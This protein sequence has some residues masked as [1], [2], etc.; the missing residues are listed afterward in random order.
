MCAPVA[1]RMSKHMMDVI[2]SDM[3]SKLLSISD[4]EMDLF[5]TPYL[6]QSILVGGFIERLANKQPCLQLTLTH[7][8]L[9]AYRI[10][11]IKEI[12]ALHTLIDMNISNIT[13]M[14]AQFHHT[15]Q[16]ELA[17]NRVQEIISQSRESLSYLKLKYT[18]QLDLHGFKLKYLSCEYGAYLSNLDCTYMRSCSITS[19]ERILQS[20]S[21]T[22]KNITHLQLWLGESIDRLCAAFPNLTSLH[23]LILQGRNLRVALLYCLP[24]SIRKVVYRGGNVSFK[25]VKS[26][27][28]WSKSRDACV[29]CVLLDC[30]ITAKLT[31]CNWMKQQD[32]IDITQCE[33]KEY[34]ISKD[35]FIS[36]SWSTI[37]SK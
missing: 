31:T 33:F 27:V 14:D 5:S 26:M 13:S 35:W 22:G 9:D 34:G 1:E 16:Q 19:Q 20:M 30:R 36:V 29:R 8:S 12:D 25:D 2:T 37:L 28:E 11:T 23:T 3:E 6:A 4:Q 7:I 21:F 17:S 15:F 18:G 10:H 32:G 24:E